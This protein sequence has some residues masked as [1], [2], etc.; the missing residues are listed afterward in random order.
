MPRRS[1][2]SGHAAQRRDTVHQEQRPCLV[3]QLADLVDG[4][5]HA[6]RCLGVDD[7]D[8]LGVTRLEGLGDLLWPNSLAPLGVNAGDLGAGALGNDDLT[9]AKDAVHTHHHLIAGARPS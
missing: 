9:L 5:E 8:D 1:R 3:S 6:S 7:G 2:S 4:L